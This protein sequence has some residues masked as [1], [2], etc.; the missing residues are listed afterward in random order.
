MLDR[1]IAALDAGH[2]V[3]VS[4]DTLEALERAG[5]EV[6]SA[7]NRKQLGTLDAYVVWTIGAPDGLEFRSNM[8]AL[9]SGKYLSE[10]A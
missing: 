9:A 7:Y 3:V 1:I 5:V 2:C 6:R 10:I 4:L 8:T